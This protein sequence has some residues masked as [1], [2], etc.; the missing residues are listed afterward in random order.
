[1]SLIT[2]IGL[3]IILF[4]FIYTA[5]TLDDKHA[6]LKIILFFFSFYLVL[7]CAKVVLD[8]QQDCE[9]LLKNETVTG[10]FTNYDYERVCFDTGN[11]TGNI[12]FKIVNYL[13]RLFNWYMYF[14]IVYIAGEFI[15]LNNLFRNKIGAFKQRIE[16]FFNTGG[17]R[18]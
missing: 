15:G 2:I 1:M 18:G 17:D 7:L 11:N 5:F 16:Q 6:F 13:I 4:F 9:I 8:D 3:G 10:N 12:V 14:L